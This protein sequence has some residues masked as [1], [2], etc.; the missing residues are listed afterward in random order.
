M[1]LEIIDDKYWLD[2]AKTAVKESISTR[3]TAAEK[4]QKFIIWAWPIYTAT[5][6]IG[7]TINLLDVGTTVS[8]LLASPIVF[9]LLAYWFAEV[10]QAP[11]HAKFDPRIPYEI[12]A[13]YNEGLKKKIRKF[14]YAKAFTF[15]AVL[16]LCTALFLI[17][18]YNEKEVENSINEIALNY[19][20]ENSSVSLSGRIFTENPVHISFDS[21]SQK[22]EYINFYKIQFSPLDDH[23]IYAKSKINKSTS[24]IRA[25]CYWQESKTEKGLTQYLKIN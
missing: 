19:E 20:K 25:I 13:A 5:F 2:Y 1:S 16:S 14:Q 21:L 22:G 10:C 9:M 6:T 11:I 23:I 8:I 3:N 7:E 17:N 15:M 18:F 24:K 4:L 12:R